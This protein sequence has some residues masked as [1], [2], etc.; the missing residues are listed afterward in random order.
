VGTTVG[1]RDAQCLDTS[2]GVLTEH[3]DDTGAKLRRGPQNSIKLKMRRQRA[4]AAESV[5]NEI[6]IG[7]TRN[8]QG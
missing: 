8:D 6:R 5:P 2:S 7:Q 4:N 3:R 1:G